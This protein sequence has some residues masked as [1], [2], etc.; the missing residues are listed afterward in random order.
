MCPFWCQALSAASV[1][2]QPLAPSAPWRARDRAAAAT[3]KGSAVL[4]GGVL[5]MVVSGAG[6]KECDDKNDSILSCNFWNRY[7]FIA[8]FYDY[9][10]VENDYVM[11]YL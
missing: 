7:V 3:L 4:T 2:W 10:V 1:E 6:G 9:W 5:A 8:A 11:F